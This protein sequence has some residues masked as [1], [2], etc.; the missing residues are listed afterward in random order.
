MKQIKKQNNLLVW[1]PVIIIVMIA[2]VAL[3]SG[4]KTKQVAVVE[5]SSN[6]VKSVQNKEVVTTNQATVGGGSYETYS[7][8]KLAFVEKGH[9]VLFFHA[10]WCPSCRTLDNDIK[11]NLSSIPSNL[12]ILD[13]D[14]DDS[15]DLKKKYGVTTQHTLVQVDKDGA[16][17]GKWIGSPTLSHLVSQ[18]K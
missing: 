6:S 10:S 17:I 2:F 4:S 18:V 12:K 7:V 3:S 14:Y 8:E 15:S 11:G 5:N 9:V 16:M 1:I 13:V